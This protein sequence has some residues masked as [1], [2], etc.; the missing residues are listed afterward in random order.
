MTGCFVHD[1]LGRMEVYDPSTGDWGAHYF[2]P[3]G[4]RV[5]T[6]SLEAGPLVVRDFASEQVEQVIPVE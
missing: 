1:E 2:S 6:T 3:D 5:V 4:R